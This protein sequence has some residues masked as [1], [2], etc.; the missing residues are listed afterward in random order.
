[1]PFRSP[2]RTHPKLHRLA[3]GGDA[4]FEDEKYIFVAASRL[5]V[6]R[7]G[8]PAFLRRRARQRAW[9]DLKLCRPNGSAGQTIVS[10]RDGDAY[11]IARRLGWGDS[12]DV[13]SLIRKSYDLIGSQIS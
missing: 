1:M 2:R 11:R 6:S 3:K 13:E 10:K 4:P 12:F 9:I 8:R 7:G 5:P